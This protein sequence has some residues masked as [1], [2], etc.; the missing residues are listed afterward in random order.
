MR[1]SSG[2]LIS[3]QKAVI[4]TLSDLGERT[5]EIHCDPSMASACDHDDILPEPSPRVHP[6]VPASEGIRRLDVFYDSIVEALEGATS[7]VIFGEGGAKRELRHRL[8]EAGYKGEMRAVQR[9][10]KMTEQ[11]IV[12]KLRAHA[13][14]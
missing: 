6:V 14:P 2:I 13:Y 5:M 4:T 1:I 8:L 11:Q 10:Q 12:A 9:S 7:V 3:R